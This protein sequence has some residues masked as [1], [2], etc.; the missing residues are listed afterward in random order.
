MEFIIGLG[1]GIVGFISNNLNKEDISTND[2]IIK[3]FNQNYLTNYRN[4]IIDN[5]NTSFY[6]SISDL[7]NKS[8]EDNPKVINNIYRDQI[9][10]INVIKK[11]KN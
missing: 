9:D 2:N 4:N 1:L 6:N 8:I 3:P 11:K 5:A 7:H 10:P